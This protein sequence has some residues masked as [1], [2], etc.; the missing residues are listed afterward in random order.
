MWSKFY[1]KGGFYPTFY[2][3]VWHSLLSILQKNQTAGLTKISYNGVFWLICLSTY[4][5][6]P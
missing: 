1:Y 6:K 2:A 5:K 4:V 3:L